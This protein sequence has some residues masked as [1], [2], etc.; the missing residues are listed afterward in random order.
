LL[1]FAE[2]WRQLDEGFMATPLCWPL[3]CN[4]FRSEE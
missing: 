2:I 3:A 4:F 1:E